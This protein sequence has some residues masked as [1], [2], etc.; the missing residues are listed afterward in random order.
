MD[1]LL[2]RVLC[3]VKDRASTSLRLDRTLNMLSNLRMMIVPDWP[4]ASCQTYQATWV[5]DLLSTSKTLLHVY[6]IF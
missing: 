2:S 3:G 6:I 1:S 5:R 4:V